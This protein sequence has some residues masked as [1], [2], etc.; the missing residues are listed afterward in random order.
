MRWKIP[1]AGFLL[2][3]NSF[4]VSHKPMR[5]AVFTNTFPA[6]SETFIDRQIEGLLALGHRVDIYAEHRPPNGKKKG[7]G[8]GIGKSG[9]PVPRPASRMPSLRPR[10]TYIDIPPASGYW[11]MPALPPWGRTWLPGAERPVPNMRRLLAA[12]PALARSILLAPRVAVKALN[13]AEYGYAAASLSTLYRVSALLRGRGRYDLAHAHFGPVANNVRF[14]RELWRVPLVVSFHGYDVGAWPRDKGDAVYSRLF[15]TADIVTANS[16]YTRDRLEALGCPLGKIRI[17]HMG[18]NLARFCFRERTPPANGCVEILSVGRLVEKKGFEY[19]IR[20]VARLRE[21]HPGIHY[22]IVGDGPLGEHLRD[23]ACELGVQ[24]V[25]SFL[26]AGGETFVRQKMDEAHIFVAPSITAENGDVE[27]Q[28]LVLQEAQACG[29]PVLATD[30]NGFPEGMLPSRSGFLVPER[31]VDA[32]AER[33]SYMIERGVQWGEWG[34]A[35]RRH[36]E[37]H[38][39]IRTLSRQLEGVYEQ[40]AARYRARWLR[41]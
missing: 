39:D 30:H 20:A 29:L 25:V 1:I 8:R 21:A 37:E 40:A 34:R 27:G 16:R 32:L 6:L 3:N 9:S 10:T 33:L 5:V 2:Y 26:S 31:D 17:L 23:L 7:G 11:E 12:L 4:P 22:S 36:V 41:R 13:P 19:S 24:D 18:L 15:R 14:V 38:Y 28:G 35:G